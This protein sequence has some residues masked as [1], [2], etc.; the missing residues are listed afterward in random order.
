MHNRDKCR[1]VPRYPSTAI[2]QT[3]HTAAAR[4]GLACDNVA[5]DSDGGHNCRR[6][7]RAEHAF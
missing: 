1:Y 7:K 2:L 6:S 3:W 5:L 4:E